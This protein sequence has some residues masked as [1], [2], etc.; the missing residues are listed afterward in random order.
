[1]HPNASI[2]DVTGATELCI[3]AAPSTYTANGV[4]LGGNGVG[5]W[6]SSN[7]TVATVGTDGVVTVL[8]DGTTDITY[9]ITGGCN[10]TA[11]DFVAL[12]VHP[13]FTAGTISSDGETVCS[14]G[15]PSL[16]IGSLVNATG[17]D[18]SITYL[19]K[20][21]TDGFY[22]TSVEIEHNEAT[23]DPAVAHTVTTWYRRYANDGSCNLSPEESVGEWTVTV[24]D[25]SAGTAGSAQTICYQGDPEELTVD[26]E[27][28]SGTPSFQ[29]QY[30][31]DGEVFANVETDGTSSSYD[32]PWGPTD[33]TYYRRITTSTLHSVACSDTSNVV[34]IRVPDS[35]VYAGV[36]VTDETC[37]YA[38]D[39]KITVQNPSGGYNNPTGTY[40]TSIDGTNWFEVSIAAPKVFDNLAAST[41]EVFL[42][43]L[44][45]P[46]CSVN[47]GTYTINEPPAISITAT[48]SSTSTERNFIPDTLVGT[49]GGAQA[50]IK[51]RT[52]ENFTLTASATGGTGALS[53]EW[54]TTAADTLSDTD[55]NAHV[56]TVSSAS[57]NHAGLYTVRVT[58][59]NECTDTLN[60]EVTVYDNEVW[61]AT[62][63]SD[64]NAGTL[65]SPLL[66]I[67]KGI[68]ATGNSDTINVATGTYSESPVLVGP[69]LIVGTGSPLVQGVSDSNQYFKYAY[70][71]YAAASAVSD[72]I[73]GFN[74][75]SFDT[76]GTT[77]TAGISK[78]IDRVSSTGT[79]YIDAGT[80]TISS[81]L[82]LY[83]G[84]TVAGPSQESSLTTSCDLVP[85][86]T[87]SG[88]GTTGLKLFTTYGSTNKTLK[89]LTLRN[90]DATGRYLEV[91]SGS[92]GNIATERMVFLNDAGT[93]LFGTMNT[94]RSAGAVNDVA[95]LISDNNDFGFGTG[96]VNYGKYAPLVQGNVVGGW[97]AEDGGVNNDNTQTR[98]LYGYAGGTLASGVSTSTRPTFR[99][100]QGTGVYNNRGY[101][102]F[103]GTTDYLDANTSTD[104][105]GGAAKSV[106]VV[107]RTNTRTADM[108]IYKHGN[109]VNGLSLNIEDG[110]NIEMNIYNTGATTR[111]Y[112]TAG[113]DG[114]VYI[115]QMYFD[116]AS[117]SNRVGMSLDA[118]SGQVGEQ[119]FNS[120]DF[121]VTTLTTPTVDNASKI[122]VGSRSGSMY[123]DGG[124]ITTT[125]RD[126]YF[127][128]SVAEI[129]VMNTADKG[130]RDATYCYLRNKYFNGDQNVENDLQRDQDVIAGEPVI[131]EQELFA[132]PNPADEM[133]DIEAI[134]P[135]G[136]YV[137]VSLHDAIGREVMSIFEGNVPN[138]AQLPL[139]AN[140]RDL[141]SGAYLLRVVGSN[142]QYMQTPVVIRH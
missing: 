4:V 134:V 101:L 95:K 11:S 78:A 125:T 141:P 133:L 89:D 13:V 42:R 121:A 60:V 93:Q 140:V 92:N 62:T 71:T 139:Q 118:A 55:E 115:A 110:G 50:Y 30:S 49:S 85:T 23:Y 82:A 73:T 28:Y 126:S 106:F 34:L 19:W 47:I 68:D 7:E 59:E 12:T 104:I 56:W 32:P 114:T 35:T 119:L 67:Q 3:G 123:I 8:T 27:S 124:T 36:V 79:V 5:A 16:T 22:Y 86:V 21:S 31:T 138:N 127:N 72:S 75:N 74:E 52:G 58:D 1:V 66:T 122:G 131:A 48:P 97:K 129:I 103:D 94:D 81:T 87:I 137:R 18:E 98:Y 96:T 120:T 117:T 116:G 128:G 40:E 90:S 44:V 91:A 26:G 61:V 142:D 113:S 112:S 14:G 25:V 65:V 41:Y 107:F 43:D 51:V 84:I 88:T 9:T 10:G 69:R 24:N 2:T 76:V 6:S 39:G 102:N 108:V 136:G 132:Y 17:G 83:N 130:I 135:V 38:N 53:Y 54:T 64:N 37:N 15:I 29:W 105:N 80:Y 99:K 33:S 57:V 109:Q 111:T 20:S 45:Y 100:S 70:T 77:T 46:D 63:G